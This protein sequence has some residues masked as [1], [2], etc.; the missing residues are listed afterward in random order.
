MKI[1]LAVDGSDQ[2][3]EAVGA[4]AG[5]APADELIL[6][7]VIHIPGL[8]YPTIGAGLAK[9]LSMAVEQAMREEG[10]EVLKRALSNLPLHPGSITKRLE[11]GDPAEIILNVAQEKQADLIV[12]GARGFGAFRECLFGS[13]SHR[14]MLHA[15]CSTFIVKKTIPHIRE[16]LLPIER[17]EDAEVVEKFLAKHPFRETVMVKVLH[18][19]PIYHSVWSTGIMIPEH[20]RKEMMAYAEE[21]T[22]GLA[23]RL[24]AQGYHTKAVAVKGMPVIRIEEE[25][26]TSTPDLIMMR[27]HS[28]V[29]MS[30]FLL[31]SVSHSVAHHLACSV[32]FIR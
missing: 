5:F 28:R 11:V 27:T 30:R 9:D 13:V 24:Q 16:V 25:V 4:L 22:G 10:E 3:Q 6:L 19:V 21:L 18:A 15:P 2:S 17:Q 14:V 29:G 7:H 32:L 26:K 8:S 12:L 20:V 31:G 23:T 1:L